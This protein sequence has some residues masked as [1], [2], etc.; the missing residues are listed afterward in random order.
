METGEREGRETLS[1][2]GGKA[3]IGP[4]EASDER[5][6][7]AFTSPDELDE[8]ALRMGA[9]AEMVSDRMPPRWLAAGELTRPGRSSIP[10]L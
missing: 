9:A 3:R 7:V 2:E 4:A 8:M 5:R 10:R 1:G 6:R